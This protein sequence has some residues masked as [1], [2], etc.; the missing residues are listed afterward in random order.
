MAR[1]VE[2]AFG[3]CVGP[4]VV[5]AFKEDSGRL[6]TLVFAAACFLR[7][8]RSV[9]PVPRIWL[10]PRFPAARSTEVSWLSFRPHPSE[11]DLKYSRWTSNSS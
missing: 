10:W 6:G 3:V 2:A 9:L 4:A 8:H 11:P 7:C 5:L 1:R